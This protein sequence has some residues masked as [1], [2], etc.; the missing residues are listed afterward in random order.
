M[1][2]SKTIYQVDAFTN[3]PFQGNP[4]GVL[5]TDASIA[6]TRM[7]NMAMEMNLSETAFV[8]SED[9]AF[10]IR[11]FTPEKEIPLCGHATLA[12]AH[13][14]YELG[15]KQPYEP[16]TFHTQGGTLTINKDSDGIRMVFPTYPIE[17]ISNYPDFKSSVGFEPLETYKSTPE[18]STGHLDLKMNP[19]QTIAIKGTA[20][21]VFTATLAI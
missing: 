1:K 14:I 12:S 16:I 7:Q 17:K 13:I 20:I 8:V 19:D 6:T 21:T 3:T 11:Y 2:N 9:D 10:S 5:I 15:L 18:W 4:A